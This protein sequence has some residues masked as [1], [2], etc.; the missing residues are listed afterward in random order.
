MKLLK[1]T[2]ENFKGIKFFEMSPEG[3]DASIFGDNA[4]GKT[5]I[6]D[7][8]SWLLFD[9]SAD[10]K[11]LDP[12]TIDSTGTETPML[13]HS[14]EAVFDV[15]GENVKLK[16]VFT[17]KY[18]K[19]RGSTK[20]SFTGHETAYF[21]DDVPVKK[22]EYVSMAENIANTETF[23]LLSD[24]D[25]FAGKIPWQ[26]R[27]DIVLEICGDISDND[28]ISTTHEISGLASLIGKHSVDD[29][30]KILKASMKELNDSIQNI[31]IRVDEAERS[32]I[33]TTGSIGDAIKLAD[34]TSKLVDKAKEKIELLKGSEAITKK[35]SNLAT[36][37]IDLDRFKFDIE[38]DLNLVRDGI[39]EKMEAHKAVI[40]SLND[41]RES[42]ENANIANNKAI[43]VLAENKKVLAGEWHA[44]NDLIFD[45]ESLV[46]PTCNKPATP[47]ESN[48]IVMG[49]NAEKSKKLS[50][51][52]E[53][54]KGL[55]DEIKTISL[56]IEKNKSEIK[57]LS[58]KIKPS[59]TATE[60]LNEKLGKVV[61]SKKDVDTIT[62]KINAIDDI[63]DEIKLLKNGSTDEL[64][65]AK[66]D[67]A[68]L[69]SE[70]KE[71]Q[72]AIIHFETNITANDRVVELAD[73]E[74]RLSAKYEELEGQLFLCEQFTRAKVGAIESKVADH[75]KSARFKMFESQINEGLREI[76]EVTMVGIPYNSGLNN[77][78]K[79]NVGLDIINTLSK[80]YG[81]NV[82]V[83]IDNAESV[84]ETIETDSQ[85]IKL[86]VSPGDDHLRVEI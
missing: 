1:L 80:H 38:K 28:I 40:L 45:K 22:K 49:F 29:F 8:V 58:E 73:E 43:D 5:T 36:L 39:R 59:I 75:F 83:L 10:D 47:E 25:Y 82:P 74:K 33:E 27:R 21:V 62:E 16:K 72:T 24:V 48:E 37:E 76:C 41:E 44:V 81:V 14:A 85:V 68:G 79:I 65:K 77:A 9:K 50:A 2:L 52:N 34:A 30:Q 19:K 54:G 84:V 61:I 86:I 66:E 11:K 42:L 69:E 13:E 15:D 3:N 57:I 12:K 78:A 55:N 6:K 64:D 70:L 56:A 31:P 18:T 26:K 63:K 67:L 17:E 60:S 51:I 7:A 71:A 20:K 53:K 35:G 23:K 46:C 4:T 32:K